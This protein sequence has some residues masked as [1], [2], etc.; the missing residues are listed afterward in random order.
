MNEDAR[1]NL[2]TWERRDHELIRDH[3]NEAPVKFGVWELKAGMNN[4]DMMASRESNWKDSWIAPDR[5]KEISH[6]KT[7]MRGW[8]RTRTT[9]LEENGARYGGKFF[10]G[11][12]M[13]RKIT[14]NTTK[15]CWGTPGWKMEGWANDEKNLKDLGENIWLMINHSY[16]KL[17]KEFA[18][19]S[20]KIRRVW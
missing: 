10:F 16:V 11:L 15:N 14:R 9:N 20:G 3:L 12:Q 19:T 7:I 6:S 17:W 4:S 5:W 18:N 2:D 8:S 1:E 13:Q